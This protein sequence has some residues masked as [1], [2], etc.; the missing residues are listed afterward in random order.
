MK[1]HYQRKSA[2]PSIPS[3][4]QAT[5]YEEGNDGILQKQKVPEKDGSLGPAYY[6]IN[7]VSII[8]R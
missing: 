2:P 1:V 3:P 7:Y 5:G 8:N 4:G 6:K